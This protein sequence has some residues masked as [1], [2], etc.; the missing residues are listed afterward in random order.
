MIVGNSS[1]LLKVLVS[2]VVT[3]VL[4]NVYLA[5]YRKK[6]AK[7]WNCVPIPYEK[8]SILQ[9]LQELFKVIRIKKEGKVPEYIKNKFLENEV[10]TLGSSTLGKSIFLTKNP[11]NI[12]AVVATLFDDF[13]VGI[14]PQCFAPLLGKGIF[15][16]EGERWKH[17][18]TMLRPQFMR[19]QIVRVK[20]L[21]SHVQ[22]FF[23][24][25]KMFKG[26]VFDIQPIFHYLTLDASTEFLF[27]ESLGSLLVKYCG[28]DSPVG[29]IEE[30]FE[31]SFGISQDYMM[32]RLLAQDFYFLVDNR[33]FRE[34]NKKVRRLASYYVD[35]VLKLTPE[36]LEA[37]SNGN[38]IF[39]NELVKETRNRSV[40]EDESLSIMLAG[41]NTTASLLSFLFFELSR[42][43]DVWEKLKTEIYRTFGKGDEIKFENITFE[44]MKRCNYL[45]WVINEALRMYPPVPANMR[46]AKKDLALPKGG[47]K[48]QEDPIFVKKGLTVG[49]SIYSCHRSKEYF[50][51]D[52]DSFIPE[53]W[54]S[55]KN[56]GWAFMPFSSGPRICLGQQFALAEAS[57][58][59]IRIAQEFPNLIP[60]DQEYPPKVISNATIRLMEGCNIRIF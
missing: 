19:E 43:K 47:G 35:K 14:R 18:R 25:V 22:T 23:K 5:Y 44:S 56:I 41:R 30:G 26:E 51:E 17:S 4:Y 10:H 9:E 21:E 42:N 55:L 33:E 34:A 6:L 3:W 13:S 28:E 48:N 27:G 49:L 54:E 52:A 39:L 46:V 36:E 58:L 29:E 50:G 38:Y 45:K 24:V 53:R 60:Q 7:K 20:Y 16:S 2:L 37:K 31:K 1:I 8:R 11:D 32:L 57:Y 15:A 59:T 40:L 12:K